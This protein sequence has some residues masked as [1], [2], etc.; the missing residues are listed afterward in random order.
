[1][2]D[3]DNLTD[4][5]ANLLKD[6]PTLDAHGGLATDDKLVNADVRGTVGD[7]GN[8]PGARDDAGQERFK[9]I[10]AE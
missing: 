6:G 2:T 4:T 5:E 7:A 3:S 1:M 8:N 10:D 9:K